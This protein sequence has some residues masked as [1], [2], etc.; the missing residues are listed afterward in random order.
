MLQGSVAATLEDESERTVHHN[1]PDIGTFVGRVVVGVRSNASLEREFKSKRVGH[2]AISM[3]LLTVSPKRAEACLLDLYVVTP[4]ELGMPNW[5]T[6]AQ[7]LVA[8]QRQGFVLLTVSDA[9]HIRC[10]WS[11]VGHPY[12]R[13]GCR[14]VASHGLSFVLVK[15]TRA[16]YAQAWG[17][18]CVRNALHEPWLFGKR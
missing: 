16:L 3:H 18:T 13:A 17:H 15:K 4:L 7:V 5:F 6:D 1:Q 8:A 10:A 12:V 14:P 2:D 11:G 9:F